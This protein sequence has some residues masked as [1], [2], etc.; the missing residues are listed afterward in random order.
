VKPSSAL[1]AIAFEQEAQRR[2]DILPVDAAVFLTGNA[3]AVI[4]DAVEHQRRRATSGL[5]PERRCDLL[6]V[7]WLRSN[8]HSSLARRA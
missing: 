2:L 1:D 5:E 8:C 4:D 6:E 3:G 7:R